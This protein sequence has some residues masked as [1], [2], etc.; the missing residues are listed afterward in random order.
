MTMRRL[1]MPVLLLRGANSDLIPR[2]WADRL[3]Q[4]LPKAR[5]VEVPGVGHAPTLHEPEAQ[6]ALRDFFGIA[7]P[8]TPRQLTV[9]V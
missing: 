9:S 3:V 2:H 6:A 1:T 8:A 4:D 7:A 5:C